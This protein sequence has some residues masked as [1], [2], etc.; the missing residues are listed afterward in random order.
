MGAEKG[1]VPPARFCD[2]SRVWLSIR[3][4]PAAMGECCI[5][6]ASISRV[7]P[8]HIFRAF[9]YGIVFEEADPPAGTRWLQ[10]TFHFESVDLGRELNTSFLHFT[11]RQEPHE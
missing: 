8:N 9:F 3:H 4:H 7:K 1:R 2:C 6:Q 10:Q 5:A 11:V